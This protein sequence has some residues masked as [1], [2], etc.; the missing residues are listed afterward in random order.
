MIAPFIAVHPFP[1]GDLAIVAL[2]AMSIA[3]CSS[4]PVE[5]RAETPARANSPRATTLKSVNPQLAIPVASGT[6]RCDENARVDV[7][8]DARDAT[9]IDV[10]WQ[11]QR[12]TLT[13]HDSYSGLPR[14][15]DS[16]SKLVWV[17]LPWKGLLLDGRSGQ[18]LA[19]ECKPG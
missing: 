6:Y 7:T 18:P 14:Y 4:Q 13:R 11:G 17:V 12:Y 2:A 1:R 5:P 9:R 19:N 15:E 16:V 8:P 3:G 10:G